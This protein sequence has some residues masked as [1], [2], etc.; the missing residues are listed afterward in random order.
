MSLARPSATFARTALAALALSGVLAN[1]QAA[2]VNLR[3]T[4][5]NVAPAD[6]VAFAPLHFG[7][8]NGSFDGF[9]SGEAANAA[10]AAVAETGS[11]ALWLPAFLAADP[12]AAVGSVGGPLL[13]GSTASMTLSVDSA[14]NQFFSFAAMV[15]PSNDKFLGNDNPTAFRIFDDA[16]NLLLGQINQFA[17]QVWDAGSETTDASA[18]AFLGDASLH[19]AENGVVS[20]NFAEL[21]AYNGLS[22]AAGYVFNNNLQADTAIY[23]IG[24]QVVP[25][26]S[27]V[28]I[29]ALALGLL[30]GTRRLRRA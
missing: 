15:L 26:P 2:V 20:F 9:N 23:R 8:G 25:E 16:G 18:A 3:V 12:Q 24:L 10:I 4:V 5:E 30:V 11:G 6:G 7:V 19:T 14:V 29:V 1:A 21:S 13:A 28:A 27:S 22:T 17:R